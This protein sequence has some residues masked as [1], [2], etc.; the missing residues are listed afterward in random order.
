MAFW[1]CYSLVDVYLPDSLKIIEKEAFG[2]GHLTTVV[3]SR[4]TIIKENA[5]PKE[6]KILYRD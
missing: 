6:C 5:F 4:K 3:V 2:N 1:S